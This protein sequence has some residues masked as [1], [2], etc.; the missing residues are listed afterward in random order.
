M[1]AVGWASYMNKKPRLRKS[2]VNLERLPSGEMKRAALISANPS[3]AR[4]S[5]AK[6]LRRI[7]WLAS[8]AALPIHRPYPSFS[9]H[10]SPHATNTTSEARERALYASQEVGGN[11]A[12]YRVVWVRGSS[13][14]GR[15][16]D[17]DRYSDR[18][19]LPT[20][21]EQFGSPWHIHPRLTVTRRTRPQDTYNTAIWPES[22]Q[23]NRAYTLTLGVTI[24]VA[25]TER[26][27]S[28][29]PSS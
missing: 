7:D 22:A 25:D 11:I 28:L 19:G 5:L 1:L 17:T 24:P 15:I 26:G 12:G 13:G 14:E 29:V 6:I 20:K 16:C 8:S 10:L 23:P 4:L 2:R 27:K 21:L 9:S 3:G 18:T